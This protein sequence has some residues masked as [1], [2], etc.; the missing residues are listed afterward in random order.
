MTH[1]NAPLTPEGRRRLCERIDGGRP[2]A[3]VA[4]EGGVSRQT[5]SKWYARWLI[6][7]E[8][9]LEDVSSRPERS[10]TAIP[11]EVEQAILGL[12]TDKKWG[13]Q[14]I[15]AWLRELD[16]EVS[17]STVQRVLE[18]HGMSRLRDMD[19]P[20][21]ESKV[22]IVR[23]EWEN[24]GDMI[25]VDVKK[26]GVIPT[27]GGWRVHGR[28]SE[29]G[30]ASQR[31]AA[32]GGKKKLGYAYLHNA[33]DD[34]SRLAYT[35]VHYNEKADTCAEFWFRAVK[36]F[37]AHGINHIERCLT[38]NGVSY[39]SRRWA[40]ALETTNT[41]HKRTRPHTPRTNGKVERYNQIMMA[42]WLYVRPYDSEAARTEYLADF[43]NYY[44]YERR[45]SGIGYRPPASRVPIDTFRIKPQS[46]W[47]EQVDIKEFEAQGNLLDEL[48]DE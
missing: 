11:E 14:R 42:E 48:D 28:D 5:L 31:V 33:V 23:Y 27:G 12:R 45:H 9:A 22:E 7:G 8:E 16:F 41:R 43:L 32:R 46:E 13:A 25:H 37:H 4:T 3:H 34:C 2:I 24:P 18:R 47:L 44:N 40:A 17:H 39:R 10:P 35:E 38:D 21:G 26:V 1:K 19:R 6:G 30:R 29:A 20:T 36:F 15:A